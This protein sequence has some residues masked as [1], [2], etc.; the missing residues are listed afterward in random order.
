MGIRWFL[1]VLFILFE[2]LID[3]LFNI[4]YK[5]SVQIVMGYL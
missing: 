4:Y 5:H 1:L 2:T 3:Y